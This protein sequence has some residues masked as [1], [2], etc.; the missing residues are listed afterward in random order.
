[1]LA[2][3]TNITLVQSLYI[4]SG[5]E[6]TESVFDEVALINTGAE[7]VSSALVMLSHGSTLEAMVLLRTA[8]ESGCASLHLHRNEEARRKY[9][10]TIS[11]FR[12]GRLVTEAKREIP[13]LGKIYGLL[14]NLAVHVDRCGHGARVEGHAADGTM[15]ISLRLFEY[16]SSELEERT[17][18]LLIRLVALMLERFLELVTVADRGNA[19]VVGHTKLR[20]FSSTNSTIVK[21]YD[22]LLEICKEGA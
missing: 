7:M 13:C 19:V 20:I 16:S 6:M 17:L 15:R 14:S 21:T 9:Y 5:G 12:S 3:I 8:M 22:E 11:P 10:S 18:L 2:R 4:L 1:M